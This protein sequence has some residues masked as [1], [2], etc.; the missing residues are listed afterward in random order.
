M[1]EVKPKKEAK[2]QLAEANDEEDSSTGGLLQDENGEN[3]YS[4]SLK[5]PIERVAALI[6]TGGATKNEIAAETG[7][8]LNIDS[9]E[10]EVEISSNDSIKLYTAREIIKAIGRGFNPKIALSLLKPDYVFDII[11]LRQIMKSVAQMQRLKGRVIG[12]GGKARST[13]EGLTDTSIS[14]YGKTIAIIGE[15]SNVATAKRAI[16]SLLSGSN[17]SSVYNWLE[18]HRRMSKADEFKH[19]FRIKNEGEEALPESD[20]FEGKNE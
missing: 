2:P 19:E 1:A 18:K 9:K 20:E 4:Y 5:I 10:G 12:E 13:I 7:C 16:E 11:E 14:V 3:E 6:G 17:H 15:A 8:K